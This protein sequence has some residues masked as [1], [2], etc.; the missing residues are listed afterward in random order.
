MHWCGISF[1]RRHSEGVKKICEIFG[2]VD[3]N[4]IN[5]EMYFE[6][7]KVQGPKLDIWNS[8]ANYCLRTKIYKESGLMTIMSST[9][10]SN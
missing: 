6:T 3:K 1:C 9:Y 7:K 5:G 2:L 4:D 8:R 10:R